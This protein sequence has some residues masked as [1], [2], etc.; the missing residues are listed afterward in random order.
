MNKANET[1]TQL[2]ELKKEGIY[3]R[4]SIIDLINFKINIK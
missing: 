1:L 4:Q 2:F 3:L